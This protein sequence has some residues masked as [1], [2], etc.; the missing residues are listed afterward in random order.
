MLKL[1][2]YQIE[3]SDLEI[4]IKHNY[5]DIADIAD[6]FNSLH[7][8]YKSILLNTYPNYLCYQI[9]QTKQRFINNLAVEINRGYQTLTIKVNELWN[10]LLQDKINQTPIHIPIK[11]GI[12]A[13]MVY[14]LMITV[15]K[16][17]LYKNLIFNGHLKDLAVKLVRMNHYQTVFNH[18]I[19]IR[20][21]FSATVY[22]TQAN[23]ILQSLMYNDEITY[24]EINGIT[25][26]GEKESDNNSA[27]SFKQRFRALALSVQDL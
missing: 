11:L 22:Q 5:L 23:Q 16:M 4:N 17:P 8:L 15:Q 1:N 9:E 24:L 25:I 13:I 21:S 14:L 26:K 19:N 27:L 7:D 2:Q 20:K 12:P 10:P 6:F 18:E 3:N